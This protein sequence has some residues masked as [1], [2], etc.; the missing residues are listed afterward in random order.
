MISEHHTPGEKQRS[1]DDLALR[2]FVTETFRKH[3]LSKPQ[4]ADML[5]ERLGEPVSLSR[6]DS[7]TALT[8]VSARMPAYFLRALCDVLN[9]DDILLYLARPSLRK[10]VAFVEEA[11]KLRDACAGLLAEAAVGHRGRDASKPP[12]S[13]AHRPARKKN[14]N[15]SCAD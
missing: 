11:R 6:L 9:S 12:K 15:G 8:K 2:K 5:A 10:K 14:G 4:I 13:M 1:E 7:Y 3:P